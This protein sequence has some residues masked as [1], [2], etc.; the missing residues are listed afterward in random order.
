M[1]R[2]AV[3]VDAGYVFARGSKELC[4]VKLPRGSIGEEPRAATSGRSSKVDVAPGSQ[5]ERTGRDFELPRPG[6]RGS[7]RWC[8]RM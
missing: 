3:F 6:F 2:V 7:S 4:G 8:V 5:L 1:D